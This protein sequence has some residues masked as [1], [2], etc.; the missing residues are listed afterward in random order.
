MIR[1]SEAI[2]QVWT[3]AAFGGF[4]SR[5]ANVA[6]ATM[7]LLISLMLTAMM[8]MTV[9][10]GAAHAGGGVYQLDNPS[11]IK[12]VRIAINKSETIRVDR[13]FG[14]ALIGSAEIADVIPLTDQSIYVLGKKVGTTRLSLV[15]AQKKLLGVI[16]IEVSYD[17]TG[18]RAQLKQSLPRSRIKVSSVNGRIM[19]SGN[20]VDAPS[21]QKA[22]AIAEQ[23]AP[24]AVLNSMSVDSPQQVL[25][26]V[27]F[28]EA[29][30]DA[31]RDLG[32]NWEAFSRKAGNFAMLTGVG[33]AAAGAAVT[34]F[35]SNNVPFGTVIAR[36]LNKGTSADVIV[37]ALERRGLARRLAEPNLVALS[38]DTASFLAGGEFPFPVAQD[39]NTITIEFKK[40]GV[41]LAFTP[42]VLSSGLINLKIEP[43]VSD[44]DTTNTVTVNGTTI[45]GLVARRA[46]TTVELRDGQSFA[47]AGLLQSNHTKAHRQLPWIGKV[48]VLGALFR[49]ASYEKRETDLV[50]IVTPRLVKPARPGQKLITPFDKSVASNDPDFFLRGKHERWKAEVVRSRAGGYQPVGGHI[51]EDAGGPAYASYKGDG[52]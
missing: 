12:R 19:L 34:A 51:L 9:G 10:H 48:P 29:S 21:V 41:G 44:I 4:G 22:V 15:D 16:E 45:P 2:G 31:A 28:V 1:T 32:V 42:T 6:G 33:G 47:I 36:L 18:I 23:F 17:V 3:G 37:Q 14:E 24:K 40:F 20:V 43:E 11:N 27:R 25:L 52:S 26:E 30:R 35:P 5:T 38:G 13:P 7:T 8:A 50:I 39:N 46:R 49:S